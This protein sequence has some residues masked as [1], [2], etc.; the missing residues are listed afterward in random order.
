MKPDQAAH[1]INLLRRIAEALEVMA[2][3]RHAFHVQE[4]SCNCDIGEYCEHCKDCE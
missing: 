1:V 4:V 2:N 3:G